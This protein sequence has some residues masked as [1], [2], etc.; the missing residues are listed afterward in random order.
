MTIGNKVNDV[1]DLV[2]VVKYQDKFKIKILN[3]IECGHFWAQIL[4]ASNSLEAINNELNNENYN[5][6]KINQTDLYIGKLGA[7]LTIE[8]E[9]IIIHRAKIMKIYDNKFEV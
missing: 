9:S 7:A 8:T 4:D 3:V 2:S 6:I 5:F 1:G